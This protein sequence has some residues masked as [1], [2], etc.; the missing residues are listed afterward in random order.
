MN[1]DWAAGRLKGL[2]G[3]KLLKD[4]FTVNGQPSW[5]LSSQLHPFNGI[6]RACCTDNGMVRSG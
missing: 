2:G 6:L 4:F 3:V 5:V 1:F